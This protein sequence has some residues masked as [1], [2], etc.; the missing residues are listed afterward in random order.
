MEGMFLG[1]NPFTVIRWFSNRAG[2]S[3]DDDACSRLDFRRSLVF[4]VPPREETFRGWARA[5]FPKQRPIIEPTPVIQIPNVV[6]LEQ[7]PDYSASPPIV[8]RY[9]R[10]VAKSPLYHI[11][12]TTWRHHGGLWF[13]FSFW[14]ELHFTRSLQRTTPSIK[15]YYMGFY[16]HSCPK[17]KYKVIWQL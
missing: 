17:M 6:N 7:H 1:R 12:V 9:P 2:T 4:R 8:I 14:R 15:S 5:H 13:C 11:Q 10:P 3:L 16:I